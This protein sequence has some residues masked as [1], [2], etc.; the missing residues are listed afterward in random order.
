GFSAEIAAS[1]IPSGTPFSLFDFGN[2]EN[3][4]GASLDADSVTAQV[5]NFQRPEDAAWDPSN[6]NDFYFVTTASFT[7][8]SRLWRL[9]FTDL[10]DLAA[11]GTIDM[12]LDGT[13]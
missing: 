11:G 2:V 9:R 4:T 13:E 3:K 1:G 12:L 8:F 6:P 5:T 10:N 7:G